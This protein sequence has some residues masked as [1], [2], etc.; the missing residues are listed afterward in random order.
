MINGGHHNPEPESPDPYTRRRVKFR[1][2]LEN[3]RQR[4]V[5]AR[6]PERGILADLIDA[7]EDLLGV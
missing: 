6:E 5:A 7:L 4:L 1:A 3:L 2:T